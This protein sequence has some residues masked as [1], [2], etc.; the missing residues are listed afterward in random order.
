MVACEYPPR[1][2]AFLKACDEEARWLIREFR[3]HPCIAI[4]SGDNES[5]SVF[6]WGKRMSNF[7]RPSENLLTRRILPEA[8][9][10]CDP[11]RPFMPSSPYLS[12]QLFHDDD[13]G[14][15]QFINDHA[16]E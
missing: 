16:P 15:S 4:W 3:N 2:E 12:D 11:N 8:V 14:R 7:L 6:F 9:R 5:D 13:H 10:D 1:D